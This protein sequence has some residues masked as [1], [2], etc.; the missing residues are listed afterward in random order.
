MDVDVSRPYRD[1]CSPRD[2]QHAKVSSIAALWPQCGQTAGLTL[3]SICRSE[4]FALA[5]HE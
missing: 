3:W 1:G 4:E 2:V 5:T